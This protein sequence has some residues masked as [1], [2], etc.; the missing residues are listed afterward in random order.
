M[1]AA[2][3]DFGM[4]TSAK[5]FWLKSGL[6]FC[7]SCAA[8]LACWILW[9]G[10]GLSF[11]MLL[12][13]ALAKDM[14]VPDTLLRRIEGELARSG[15]VLKFGSAR[16]DPTGKVLLQD[17]EVRTAH[18][19]DP[20]LSCRL[21][22][23]RHDFWSLLSG[24]DLPDEIQV[25]GATLQ[26][27]AMLAPGGV[28]EPFVSDIAVTLRHRSHRWRV[29]QFSGRIG[30]LQLSLHGEFTPPRRGGGA[31]PDLQQVTTR[32][33][34]FA[35]QLAPHMA[36]LDAFD[37]PSL[38]VQLD[39][40]AGGSNRAALHL[41]A[42]GAR[43]PWDRPLT[44]GPFTA[45]TAL[46]LGKTGTHEV[47]F[48]ANWL[49]TVRDVR[50]ERLHGSAEIDFD[51]A[52]RTPRPRRA[53]VA[54]A[55]VFT[56]EG[57]I[58]APRAIATLDRWPFVHADLAVELEGEP[59]AI[60]GN[61]DLAGRSAQVHARGRAQPTL[62]TRILA[63]HT[64]RAE[65]YFR[66]GD[67]VDF[68]AE[69]VLAPGW[70]FE[71]LASRVA[72]GRLD[73]RGVGVTMA[74]GRI[75]IDGRSFLAH[76][77]RVAIG[78]STARGSYW[79]D[80]GTT[81]YRM[82]LDG[83]LQP[84]AI[85]GWFRGDWW[86]AFW[87]RWFVFPD[88]RLP[89]AEVDV[90]GRWKMPAL[91][92]NFVRARAA[93]ATVWGGDFEHVDATVFVRPAFAHGLAVHG[94]RAGGREHLTGSFKRIGIPGSSDTDRFEFDF[95]TNADPSVLGRM[96]EGRADD[97]LASLRFTEPP[98]IHA[99]GALDGEGP[100][101]VP[102]YH[103]T[104][105]TDAPLWY[106]GFPLQSAGVS[107]QAKGHEVKL[108]EIRFTAA[109]GTGGGKATLSGAPG[110]RLLGFDFHLN[111]ARL[112][113]TVRAVQEYDAA[114]TGSPAP[115]GPDSPFVRTAANSQLD[116][117]LTA[118]GNPVD[119]ASFKGSGHASL[120]GGEL[121]EVHLFGLLSQVLTGLTLSF[122]SL[123]FDTA[124]TS[125]DLDDGALYFPDLKVTGPSAAIDARGRYEFASNALDFTA[126]FKPYEQPGS[127]LAAA[128]SIVINPLTSILEL[129]LNGP[130]ANPKWSVLVSPGPRPSMAPPSAAEKPADPGKSP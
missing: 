66:F 98:S 123:K 26:L 84:T 38:E 101:L 42:A 109:G 44:L 46:T 100:T 49:E 39:T 15:L 37:E 76:D 13:I 54:A 18:F 74:R 79:M 111:K 45:S 85:S 12:Y 88:D 51:P 90:R 17:V 20:I 55:R 34:Q 43:Q 27:P 118:H 35:R 8:T 5:R 48:N 69:A 94:T 53:R 121:G 89:E 95:T 3:S 124:H 92:N 32:Y 16:F 122:S 82:L 127:L 30:R 72:A 70:R 52:A 9:I 56:P 50:I 129:K 116:V 115:A 33:L 2:P 41:I 63:A 61:V 107:G 86:P 104:G 83:R 67:P 112:G 57:E 59:I 119:L 108:D 105:R 99:W 4:S 130:L 71:R 65:P 125:F 114:R 68:D 87:N 36:R 62:I 64:P 1:T 60:D 91:S 7:G 113:A 24:W 126:R 29:E 58:A 21:L 23:A 47:H 73:S 102:D 75:D 28:A 97:V 40:D 25:E 78:A 6:R 110:E 117:S 120:T 93:G 80:F 96:L 106:Y 11:A 10:L 103:F 19:E 31:G 22:Y 81:D 14:P 77:A 128:V